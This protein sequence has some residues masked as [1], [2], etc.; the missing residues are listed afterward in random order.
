MTMPSPSWLYYLFAVLML[1][2]A[3]YCLLRLV[4]DGSRF[5]DTGWDIHVSHVAMGIAM[6][7]MFV[8]SWQFGPNWTWELIF[9]VLLVWFVVRSIKALQVFG[10]HVPH[11]AIHALMAFAMLLMYWYPMGSASSGS[12]ASMGSM[13][14]S[15]KS[16]MNPMP[17]TMS[18]KG[19]AGLFLLLATIFLASAVF[20]LASSKKGRSHHG[21][22]GEMPHQ[23]TEV[24]EEAVSSGGTTMVATRTTTKI[25]ITAKMEDL[26]HVVM[27]IGMAF[28]L[29][30]ML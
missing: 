3:A 15:S 30:L 6:A 13:G 9:G 25:E 8:M 17:V 24:V 4:V 7:G 12:S 20:T 18:S 22:H 27:C 29:I 19:D 23:H 26:T 11:Y 10:L 14:S 2:V 5:N 21:T 28:M 16:T 1:A